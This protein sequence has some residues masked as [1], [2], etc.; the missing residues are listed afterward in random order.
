ML[1]LEFLSTLAAP[2][3]ANS[4]MLNL[5]EKDRPDEYRINASTEKPN[6][7]AVILPNSLGL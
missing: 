2:Q 1:Q 7:D 5:P 4:R 6:T 3:N